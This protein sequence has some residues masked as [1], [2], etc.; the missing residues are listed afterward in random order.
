MMPLVV[1]LFNHMSREGKLGQRE[2]TKG[3]EELA[4]RRMKKESVFARLSMFE[5]WESV[6][7]LSVLTHP[8]RLIIT[9]SF[10]AKH[11]HTFPPFK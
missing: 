9:G 4:E 11:T 7:V 10:F 3:D 8:C 6:D 5:L 2:R 1:V